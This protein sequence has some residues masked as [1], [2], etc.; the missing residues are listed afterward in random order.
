MLRDPSETQALTI[1]TGE[2]EPG[3]VYFETFNREVLG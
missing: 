1:R 2:V 3:Q